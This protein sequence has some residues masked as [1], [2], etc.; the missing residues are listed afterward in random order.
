MLLS[1]LS[2]LSCNY[3]NITQAIKVLCEQ[4][5]NKTSCIYQYSTVKCI[6]T[7]S[8]LFGLRHDVIGFT[9]DMQRNLSRIG[10]LR[11]KI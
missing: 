2:I 11:R 5:P 6:V 1:V 8:F 7:S 4:S 3:I 10:R 9:A